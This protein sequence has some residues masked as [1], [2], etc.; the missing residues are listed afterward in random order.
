MSLS[1]DDR[2][3]FME[4]VAGS[5]LRSE[6]MMV[7]TGAAAMGDAIRLTSAAFRL[8]FSAALVMPPFFFRDASDEGVVRFFEALTNAVEV[9]QNGIFLYNFP[10]VSGIRF[11]PELVERLA[12]KFSGLIGGLKDSSNDTALQRA[13]AQRCPDIAM[14]PS[15]EAYLTQAREERFAG[16]ISGSVALWPKIAAA[17]W[18]G[19]TERQGRL[20]QLR[21]ALAGLPLIAAARYITAHR[22]GD[23]GWE[24]CIPPLTP[25]S[26]EQ[27]NAVS[28]LCAQEDDE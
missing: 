5:G 8:G 15:S 4:A 19:A 2:I 22:T 18:G 21:M 24:R 10:Q 13:I 27:K 20:T 7:G 3:R 17:V 28:A 9:P 23:A 26:T 12:A 16:C 25:L 6:R 11:H 1:T 14:F